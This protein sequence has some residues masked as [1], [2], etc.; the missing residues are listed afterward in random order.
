MF[1]L[2]IAVWGSRFAE[3]GCETIF[4]QM[5]K[6]FVTYLLNQHSQYA[7]FDRLNKTDVMIIT[8]GKSVTMT[9]WRFEDFKDWCESAVAGQRSKKTEENKHGTVIPGCSV[10][11]ETLYWD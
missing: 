3:N 7:A 9:I 8:L 1:K 2:A 5:Q 4:L 10:K 11:S 6:T